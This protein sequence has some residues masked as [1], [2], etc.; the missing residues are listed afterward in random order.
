MERR[1]LRIALISLAVFSLTATACAPRVSKRAP[2]KPA[3]SMIDRAQAHV[4]VEPKQEKAAIVARPA[5][6]PAPAAVTVSSE[7]NGRR[8]FVVTAPPPEPE[9]E[10]SSLPS[11]EDEADGEVSAP[12]PE[13]KKKTYYAYSDAE[14]TAMRTQ[15]KDFRKLDDQLKK[16][17][18]RSE[19]AIE[20]RE[21]I[22]T[23]IARIRMSPGGMNAKKEKK[24]AKLKAEKER[25][26]RMGGSECEPIEERL[27]QMLRATYETE[28]SLY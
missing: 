28:A 1:R 5:A 4:V 19:A 23:E 16:C 3:P 13:P 17:T 25:L 27:T 2:A 8:P 12:A 22:P 21:E 15:S 9:V 18:K 26:E 20:R 6:E 24:I 10:E 11:G 14:I 7:D